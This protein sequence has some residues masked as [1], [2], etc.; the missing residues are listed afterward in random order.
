MNTGGPWLSW[1]QLSGS[2]IISGSL[3]SKK[4]PQ[5]LPWLWNKKFNSGFVRKMTIIEVDNNQGPNV[6]RYFVIF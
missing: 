2:G 6:L 5:L 4:I 1:S 3:K